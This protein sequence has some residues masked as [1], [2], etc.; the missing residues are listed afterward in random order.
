MYTYPEAPYHHITFISHTTISI[1]YL[2]DIHTHVSVEI[3]VCI[4]V[5]R[6]EVESQSDIGDAEALDKVSFI[7]GVKCIDQVHPQ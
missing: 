2:T 5:M 3:E 1:S 4:Q 7:Q 6:Y